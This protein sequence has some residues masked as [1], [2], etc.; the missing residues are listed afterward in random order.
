MFMIDMMIIK[1]GIVVIVVMIL[2][3]IMLRVKV[4]MTMLLFS[5]FYPLLAVASILV[6]A[7]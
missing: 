5:S 3:N 7:T 1:S 6:A 2:I 4:K